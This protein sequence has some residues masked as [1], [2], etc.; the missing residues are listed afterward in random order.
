MKAEPGRV[1]ITFMEKL[2][3]PGGTRLAHAYIVAS[4]NEA[5]RMEYAARL[6]AAMLCEREDGARP[7]GVCRACRKTLAGIHPDVVRVTAELD[8]QGRRKREIGV[9]VIRSVAENAPVMPNEGRAKA[10]IVEDADTMNPQAQNAFLKLLEEP[11]ERVSFILAAANP[12]LLHATVR[13]RCETLRVNADA[14]EGEEAAA[15]ASALLDVIAKGS[16][17]ALLEWCTANEGMDSRRCEAMLR[18]AREA[19]ADVLRERGGIKLERG[20]C[21]YL[22]ALFSRCCDYLRRNVSVRSVMGL[23]AVDGIEMR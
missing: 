16:P 3:I 7:C 10:Y 21:A 14:A 20:R 23:I 8:S 15:D 18:S 17:T 22:D 1:I 2:V 11:P 19:L 12:A 6:A 4:P 13:S 9:D 5:E